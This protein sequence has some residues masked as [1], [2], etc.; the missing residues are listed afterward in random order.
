M[1]KL[2]RDQQF[3]WF[4]PVAHARARG[5]A[6]KPAPTTWAICSLAAAAL[7][8]LA[9]WPLDLRDLLLI[10]PLAFAMAALLLR[11]LVPLVSRL[12]DNILITRD[13]VVVGREVTPLARIRSATVVRTRLDG[14]DWLA[15]HLTTDTGR[16]ALHALGRR[17]DPEALAAFF[18]SAGIPEHAD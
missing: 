11:V 12:P 16:D 9:A 15:L 8:A 5:P 1:I 13:R 4:E 18:R 10:P 2:A 17:V 3:H 14:A 6:G 7:L